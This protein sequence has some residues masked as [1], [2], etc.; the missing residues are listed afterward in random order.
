MPVWYLREHKAGQ[1]HHPNRELF[2]CMHPYIQGRHP[3]THVPQAAEAAVLA[4]DGRPAV[5]V[6][7]Q[8]GAA[9]VGEVDA[10]L[11]RPPW[12]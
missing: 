1:E 7:P 10:D 8:H 3:R 4:R 9:Q 12:W 11:V 2:L 5:E 6:V